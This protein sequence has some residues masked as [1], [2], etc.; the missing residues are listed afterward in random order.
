MD[1][2]T[3][4]AAKSSRSP[5]PLEVWIAKTTTTTQLDVTAKK[6]EEKPWDILVPKRYHKYGKVFQEIASECFPGKRPWDHAIELLLD[7]PKSMDCRVY[8]LSP[9]EKEAAQKFVKENLCLKQ[10]R[11]SKSPYASGFFLVPKKDGKF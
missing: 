6:Q 2:I 10:I 9:R 7:A 5:H 3:V 1:G 8:P 4:L 11:Q